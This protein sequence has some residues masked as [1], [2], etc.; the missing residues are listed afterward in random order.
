MA[1]MSQGES[2]SLHYYSR[3][4][5][6]HLH[7]SHVQV[8]AELPPGTRLYPACSKQQAACLVASSRP[9]RE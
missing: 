2:Q 8:E 3:F 4:S 7:L 6:S 9:P 1:Y 5:V